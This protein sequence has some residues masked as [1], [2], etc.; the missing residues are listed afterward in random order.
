MPTDGNVPRDPRFDQRPGDVV[1][2]SYGTRR[3]TRIVVERSGGNITYI[4][5]LRSQTFCCCEP[6]IWHEWCAHPEVHVVRQE[7]QGEC[8]TAVSF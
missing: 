1:I 5:E 2:R 6:A 4:R 3:K 8:Q 7:E